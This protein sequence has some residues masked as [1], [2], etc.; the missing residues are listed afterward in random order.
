MAAERTPLVSI[1]VPVFNGER[2][3]RASLDALLAQSFTDLE[4]IVSDNAS[5][6]ATWAICTEAALCDP[7]VRTIRQERNLGAP[8]NW[9]FTARQARGRFFKWASAS[10]LCAPHMIERCL[11]AMQDESVVLAFGRTAF[12]DDDGRELGVFE[13]DFPVEDARPHARFRRVCHELSINNAQSGL[14]RMD[15]LRRTRLDR[16]YPGGDRVLMAE[17]AMQG[18]WKLIGEVLLYRRAGAQH[19]TAM[20]TSSDLNQMFRPGVAG[21]LSFLNLRRHVDFI[22]SALASPVAPGERLRAAMAALKGLY[23]DRRGMREDLSRILNR[24]RA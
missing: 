1:G 5:T 3:L 10:D 11:D 19:F 16:L 23:W 8:A 22:G 9:N 20:R 15:A 21:E 7:R 4:V 6:D 24:G 17:L 13:R 12:I 18:K 14:I 2:Y